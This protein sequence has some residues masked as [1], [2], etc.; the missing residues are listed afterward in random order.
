MMVLVL[1]TFSIPLLLQYVTAQPSIR[2]NPMPSSVQEGV[3]IT[4]SGMVEFNNQPLSGQTVTIKDRTIGETIGTVMSDSNGGFN[5]VWT[6]VARPEK[7]LFYVELDIPREAASFTSNMY[8]VTVLS[9]QPQNSEFFSEDVVW[10]IVGLAIAG[11]ALYYFRKY[12]SS[13]SPI[14][15]VEIRGG[16]EPN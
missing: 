16:L 13:K 6:S 3:T 7:Y 14:P 11:G 5:F 9:R 4:F 15:T 2:L 1:F 10:T 8:E 12:K